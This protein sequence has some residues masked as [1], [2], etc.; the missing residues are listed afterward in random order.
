M[1]LYL[2]LELSFCFVCGFALGLSGLSGREIHGAFHL[3][4]I[5]QLSLATII[6]IRVHINDRFMCTM[7]F[8]DS[9]GF[10]ILIPFSYGVNQ[11]LDDAFDLIPIYNARACFLASH[12]QAFNFI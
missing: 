2:R 5:V 11:Q 8:H 6:L 1:L 10:K 12:T 4:N 7:K 9:Y 3:Y